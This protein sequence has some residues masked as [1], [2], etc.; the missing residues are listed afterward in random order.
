MLAGQTGRRTDECSLRRSG[1]DITR[2]GVRD[3]MKIK[4][5]WTGSSSEV[6]DH[7]NLLRRWN[8]KHICVGLDL[9]R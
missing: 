9:I 1:S 8:F 7:R 4:P 5:L 2:V 6:I 3:S